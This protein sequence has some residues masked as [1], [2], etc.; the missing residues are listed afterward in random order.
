MRR[1]AELLAPYL[2]A[3]A[4]RYK[5]IRYRPMGVRREYAAHPTPDLAFME[6]LKRMVSEM[7]FTAVIA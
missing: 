7:G 4:I 2:E 3:G 1:T 5:L 6:K